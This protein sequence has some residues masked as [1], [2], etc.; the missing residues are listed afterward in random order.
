MGTDA[1]AV[2]YTDTGGVVTRVAETETGSLCLMSGTGASG[3]PSWTSCPGT[4]AGASKWQLAGE[5]ISPF[6]T[7]LD[8]AVGGTATTSASFQAFGIELTGTGGR[9]AKLTSDTIDTGVVLEATASAITTGTILK[10]GEGGNQNFSG[11]VIWADIDNTGGGGGAFSGDFLQ[12]DDAG[13]TV[14]GVNYLGAIRASDLTLG[15]EDT[16]ALITTSDAETLTIDPT[17]A[18]AISNMTVTSNGAGDDLTIALAG[19]SDSSLILTSSGTGTD[20][21]KL[22]TTGTG[23]DIDIDAEDGITL[24]SATGFISLDV[25]AA[26]AASNFSVAA[27]ADAEDLTLSVT[28]S[29]GD[30]ILSSVDQL[31]LTTTGGATNSLVLTSTN[32]GI[33]ITTTGAVA[34]EDIDITSSASLNLI[35]QE[36]ATDAVT[37]QSTTDASGVRIDAGDNLTSAGANG[38]DIEFRAEDDYLF[39]AAAGSELDFTA[40]AS[41]VTGGVIDLNV[42]TSVTGGFSVINNSLTVNSGAA[43]GDDYYA[44]DITLTMNDTDA[45]SFGLRILGAATANAGA[46]AYEAGIVIDNQ[47]NTA[48]S[49]ADAIRVLATTDTAITNGLNVSDGEIVNAVS[50]GTNTILA[51]GSFNIDLFNGSNDTLGIINSGSGIA[52]LGINTDASANNVLGTTSFGAQSGS[53]L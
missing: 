11:N 45:N 12:F 4:G 3:V 16:S 5:V 43:T 10:L 25:V 14:F 34:T 51:S 44:N 53:D 30:L 48:G 6:I 32:G 1:N 50:L 46:N 27:D 42:D 24:D 31:T 23:G 9:V 47:E 22:S 40:A 39:T 18:G 37:I 7:S 21:L 52:Y 33:D 15:L 28:G 13:T 41:T 49:M 36:A 2:L 35:G 20:A 19:N 8:V 38:N 17:G 26:D 29:A